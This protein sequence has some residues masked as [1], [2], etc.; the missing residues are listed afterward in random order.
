MVNG[1]GLAFQSDDVLK[2]I[3]G[4]VVQS[5][6]TLKTIVLYTFLK[7]KKGGVKLMLW[8]KREQNP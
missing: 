4:M 2:L 8:E 5:C 3:V 7:I 6:D 1:Y